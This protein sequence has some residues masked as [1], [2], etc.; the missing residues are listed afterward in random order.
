MAETRRTDATLAQARQRGLGARLCDDHA[1]QVGAVRQG[2]QQQRKIRPIGTRVH[3]VQH[4][5]NLANE[6]CEE[7]LLDST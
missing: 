6:A 7:A 5:F 1:A 2:V 3:F 4:W